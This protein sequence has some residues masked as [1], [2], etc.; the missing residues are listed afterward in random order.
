MQSNPERLVDFCLILV[1]QFALFLGAVGIVSYLTTD[2]KVW[3]TGNLCWDNHSQQ[4]QGGVW[5]INLAPWNEVVGE[6]LVISEG[7]DFDVNSL[8]NIRFA[9]KIDKGLAVN[10]P[11]TEIRVFYGNLRWGEKF[12]IIG[13]SDIHSKIIKIGVC[14]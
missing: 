4:M 5:L 13:E 8:P 12:L 7:G 3:F 2:T 9:E 6:I 14:H 10:K 11:L 1:L